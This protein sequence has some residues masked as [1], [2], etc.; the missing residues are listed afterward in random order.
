MK[1]LHNPTMVAFELSNRCNLAHLH[2]ECPV[3]ANI[4]PVFLST[5]LIKDS[6]RYLGSTQYSGDIIFS[7]YNEPLIDPRFFM[8]VEFTKNICPTCGI[9]CFTNGWSLNQY[10][11]DELLKFDVKIFVSRYTD[12]E[13]KRFESIINVF[14]GRI[15]L[16]PEVKT[17]YGSD[18]TATGPCLFPSVYAFVNHKGQFVLCCRDYEYHHII[19]DLKSVSFESILKSRYRHE[20]CDR[21]TAGDRF[22]DACRRCPFPGWGIE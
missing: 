20:I 4:D 9:Q 13:E 15:T 12:N 19:G 16:N 7:I 3:D 17:I 18:L 21:L 22:L 5:D 11:V 1:N 8:L 6:I 2:K 10:M 14:G